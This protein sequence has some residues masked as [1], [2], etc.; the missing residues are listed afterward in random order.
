LVTVPA[1]LVATPPS[2]EYCPPTMLMG[3]AVLIPEMVIAVEVTFALNTAPVT[4]VKLNTSGVV[5][6]NTV[7]TAK[8]CD[9]PPIVSMA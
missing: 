2:I 5:S 9:T 7:V 6:A 4:A 1:V 8:V 3:D